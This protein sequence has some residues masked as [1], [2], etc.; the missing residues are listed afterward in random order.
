MSNERMKISKEQVEAAQK[1]IACGLAWYFVDI[2]VDG[3][4][5]LGLLKQ[6]IKER[7]EEIERLKDEV[8]NRETWN[9]AIR[10]ALMKSEQWAK[11]WKRAA[12]HH[13]S[14]DQSC[15]AKAMDLVVQ[16]QSQLD[17]LTKAVE[18]AYRE[19]YGKPAYS[20][21]AEPVATWQARADRAWTESKARQR[22]TDRG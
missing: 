5:A 19:G 6:A 9:D 8:R 21:E 3:K 17:E 15:R 2:D 7:D 13:Y 14:G 12:K 1:V 16:L 20:Q 4:N 11:L 18:L 22:L 10:L